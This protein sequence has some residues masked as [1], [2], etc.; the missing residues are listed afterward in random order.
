VP[1]VCPACGSRR[2]RFLGLGTQKVMEETAA[3][4]PS[5]RLLRW[6][7]DSAQGRREH[8][9]IMR[10]LKSGAVDVLIGTQ[11][12]AKGLDIPAITLVGVVSADTALNLPDFRAGERT[13]QLLTQVAG[14]AGRGTAPGRVVVQ[15][16]APEHY[17]IEG[18]RRQDYRAFYQEEIK[19][20]H[21]LGNPP[22]SQL[23]SLTYSHRDEADAARGAAR[24]QKEMEQRLASQ[25]LVDIR[26]VGPAPAYPPRLRGRYRWQLLFKG[27]APARLL[28]G[29]DLPAGWVVDVDP[30]GLG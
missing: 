14:R 3:V 12:V 1:Q 5:A 15:T 11:M 13:F 18:M 2:I 4:F 7:S 20:R 25:G 24:L 10:R 9:E 23:I 6:D 29:L 26:L 30:L 16:Y 22:F 19:L 17:A 8:E 28:E 27:A 21:E